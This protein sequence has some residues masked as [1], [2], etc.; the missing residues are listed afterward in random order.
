MR[1]E[2]VC[3]AA[4]LAVAVSACGSGISVSSDWD[5]SVDFGQFQTFAV[6]DEAQGGEG[7]NQLWTQRVKSAIVTT[8]EAKGMRQVDNARNADL[9]VG[10]QVTTDQRTS[11]QTVSTGWGGYGWRGGWGGGW[12]GGMATSTTTA[13][14]YEVGTLVIGMANTAGD[15]IFHSSGSKTLEDAERSPEE[16]QKRMNDAVAKILKDFPPQSE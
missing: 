3:M 9:A 5:P 8:M 10:W 11:Y 13:Q 6:M 2:R 15:L 14:N 16:A 4:A 1:V 7:L 12:G